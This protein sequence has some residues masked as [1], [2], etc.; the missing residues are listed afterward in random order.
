MYGIQPKDQKDDY[1]TIIVIAVVCIWSICAVL[2]FDFHDD[3]EVYMGTLGDSMGILNSFFSA[4]AFAGVIYS[5]YQQR[6]MMQKQEIEI[7]N[8]KVALEQQRQ[9]IDRQ[10]REATLLSM[11][12]FH[13]ERVKQV[14]F[15]GVKG[16]QAI[17]NCLNNAYNNF[18]EGKPENSLV[19]ISRADAA[20]IF[21]KVTPVEFFNYYGSYLQS[22]QALHK[23]VVDAQ[24]KG[25]AQNRYFSII[26]SYTT[27]VEQE[28]LYL[29]AR[30]SKDNDLVILVEDFLLRGWVPEQIKTLRNVEIFD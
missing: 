10:R 24:L 14:E 21:E 20:I 29:F 11:M 12:N 22:L 6:Q 30:L 8:N 3:K 2:L 5:L 18:K 15:N 26:L 9:S 1:A 17:I 27:V 28:M 16:I 4:L 7:E 25:P 23:V 13:F 19:I